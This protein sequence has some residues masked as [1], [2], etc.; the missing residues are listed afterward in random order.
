MTFGR[1]RLVALSLALVLGGC[2]AEPLAYLTA[3][4]SAP[5][6]GCVPACPEDTK[7]CDP[8]GFKLADQ[9]CQR[10]WKE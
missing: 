10:N 8:T 9:R 6:P 3:P 5:P 1:R 4:L 7:P 2:Q